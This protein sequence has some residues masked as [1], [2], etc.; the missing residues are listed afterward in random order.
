MIIPVHGNI[1]HH[2]CASNLLIKVVFIRN[3]MGALYKKIGTRKCMEI[4][5]KNKT[6]YNLASQTQP[7]LAVSFLNQSLCMFL[8]SYVHRKHI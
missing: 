2:A 5:G 4:K 7:Q 1:E 8:Y 3:A 6:T